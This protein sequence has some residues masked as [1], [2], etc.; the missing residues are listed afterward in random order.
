[1]QDVLE[2]GGKK[3]IRVEST[4]EWGRTR[5][6]YIEVDKDYS[7]KRAVGLSIPMMIRDFD[8]PVQSMADGKYYSSKRS[9]AL[10]HKAANNPSGQDFVELG[11]EEIKDAPPPP[12]MSRRE[13]R[14]VIRQAIHDSQNGWRP[15]VAS[16]EM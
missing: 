13:E 3:V 11:N 14:E 5:I 9:L 1:M 16:I 4:N 6:R 12:P 10:S 7:S 15:E 2:M 8:E